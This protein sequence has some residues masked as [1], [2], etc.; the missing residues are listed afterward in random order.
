MKKPRKYLTAYYKAL[1]LKKYNVAFKYYEL[2]EHANFE[3]FFELVY[4]ASTDSNM[5]IHGHSLKGQSLEQGVKYFV[6]KYTKFYE[7]NKW[8]YCK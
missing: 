5:T 6:E 1:L 7:E 3:C 2:S 8:R 4:P